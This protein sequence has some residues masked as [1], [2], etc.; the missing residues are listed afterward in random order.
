[1]TLAAVLHTLVSFTSKKDCICCEEKYG[2]KTLQANTLKWRLLVPNFFGREVTPS[3]FFWMREGSFYFRSAPSFWRFRD[4][5]PGI[6]GCM[7]VFIS[8]PTAPCTLR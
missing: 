7:I 1:M 8:H 3:I 6:Y 4:I 5:P 2:N